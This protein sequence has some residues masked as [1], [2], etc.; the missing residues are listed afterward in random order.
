MTVAS[1]IPAPAEIIARA[2]ALVPTLAARSP[3]ARRRRRVWRHSSRTVRATADPRRGSVSQSGVRETRMMGA[4][5]LTG[6]N[7]I[8]LR[9]LGVTTKLVLAR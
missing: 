1:Q 3:E 4:K 7:G 5:S 9:R 6:S 2:R 8:D